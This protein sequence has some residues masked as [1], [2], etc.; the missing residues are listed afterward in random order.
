MRNAFV[1]VRFFWHYSISCNWFDWPIVILQRLAI[2]R[3]RQKCDGKNDKYKDLM[4]S[5]HF[6]FGKN[7]IFD[8]GIIRLELMLH[9]KAKRHFIPWRCYDNVIIPWLKGF[10]K[11]CDRIRKIF[12]V[13]EL[14]V[15]FENLIDIPSRTGFLWLRKYQGTMILIFF[16]TSTRYNS[17]LFRTLWS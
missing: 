15:N 4:I 11:F 10:E 5:N 6:C 17:K 13:L 2:S 14:P 7:A 12:D 3:S 16:Y 1:L 9:S 8:S